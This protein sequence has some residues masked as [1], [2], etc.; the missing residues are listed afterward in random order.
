[1]EFKEIRDRMISVN[2]IHVLRRRKLAELDILN[3]ILDGRQ[4]YVDIVR[5]D[6]E[7]FGNLGYTIALENLILSIDLYE[8]QQEQREEI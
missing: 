5:E 3:A 1:M 7:Y 8:P 6:I 4:R 2:E